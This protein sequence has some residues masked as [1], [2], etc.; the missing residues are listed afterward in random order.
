MGLIGR[1]GAPVLGAGSVETLC[2]AAFLEEG[3]LEG[4]EMVVEEIVGLMDH[5]DHGI[6]RDLGRRVFDV[7]PIGLIRPIR[8]IRR[9]PDDHR[10]RMV[11]RPDRQLA[12]TEEILA[13]FEEF[14]E[15]GP[16]H[17]DQPQFALS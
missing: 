11:L 4:L 14:L 1:M 8:S 12:K 13:V 16:G 17:V 15:T 9:I 6:G 2:E 10:L 5:A 3:S 7:R